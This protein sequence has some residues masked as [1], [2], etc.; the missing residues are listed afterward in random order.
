MAFHRLSV[1]SYYGGL[2][3]GY[4]YINNALVGTPAAA[5]SQKSG[6]PND[7]TY[8]VAFGDDATSNNANRPAL[9]LA[10]NCDLL[11]DLMR[12]DLAIPTR[13]GDV[14]AGAPVPSIVITGPDV[15]L[16]APGTPNTTAGINTF[17]QLTDSN[18]NEIVDATGTA[19]CKITA[20]AGGVPG[21]GFTAGNLTLT[22]SPAIPT[23]KTYRVYYATRGNLATI[24][25]EA[26]S[27]IKIRGAEEVPAELLTS[28]GASL[29]G[30]AGGPL[31]NN[32]S[33]NLQTTVEAQLDK[34]VGDLASFGASLIGCG[35]IG[36]WANNDEIDN[37]NLFDN[38]AQ[39]MTDLAATQGAVRIGAAALGIWADFDTNPATSIQGHL[40]NIVADLA[41]SA[42]SQKIGGAVEAGTRFALSAGTLRSQLVAISNDLDSIRTSG[43]DRI[44]AYNTRQELR[45]AIDNGDPIIDRG[46]YLVR[47]HGIFEYVNG[48]FEV[49]NDYDLVV[50]ENDIGTY[51]LVAP[52]P[53]LKKLE[54]LVLNSTVSNIGTTTTLFTDA[55]AVTQLAVGDIIE[56][57]VTA[58]VY[59][60]ATNIAIDG[61]AFVEATLVNGTN[62]IAGTIVTGNAVGIYNHFDNTGTIP[63]VSAFGVS[64]LCR[65]VTGPDLSS[66]GTLYMRAR[67]RKNTFGAGAY[68]A[69]V[70]L[71][72]ILVRHWRV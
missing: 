39:V 10:E 61:G 48:A 32:G 26:L 62:V 59:T 42:G 29:I 41:G 53:R 12:R 9:A 50:D 47:G 16:G 68:T 4:D 67:Y 69:D 64:K 65:T 54:H 21:A 1:P 11:D 7:G 14:L 27:I 57:E 55:I 45:Q 72:S 13:T 37:G 46:H 8:F 56:L 18:D 22:I 44:R 35:N 40:A 19:E 58:A 52:K 33:T 3:G 28:G 43:V 70:V 71:N 51:Y 2:P 24:P 30:Y 60:Y 20:V 15:F 66:G 63:A 6:G 36:T 25:V 5:G 23:G 34:I 17:L 49:D 38:L 31:W